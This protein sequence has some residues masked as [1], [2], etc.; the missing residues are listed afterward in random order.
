VRFPTADQARISLTPALANRPRN[1]TDDADDDA[2]VD[3]LKDIAPFRTDG[4][5]HAALA[6]A[7]GNARKNDVCY[8]EPT[9]EYRRYP[10]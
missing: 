1:A 5:L 9:N 2:L 10:Q 7:F 8:A 3:D 4:S 6:D